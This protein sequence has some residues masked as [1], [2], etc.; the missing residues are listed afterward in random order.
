MNRIIKLFIVSIFLFFTF[1]LT[2]AKSVDAAFSMSIL[3]VDQTSVSTNEQE[4]TVTATISGL[5]NPSFF[6][7]ELQK[8]SGDTYFGYSKNNLGNW[9]KVTSDSDCT[10]YYSVT[11]TN[12][13]S[14]ILGIKIGSDNAPENGT[15]LLKLRRYTSTCG[16][17]SDSD[18]VTIQINLPTPVPSPTPNPTTVSTP[19]PTPIKT[20]APTT[21]KSPTPRP[22]LTIKPTPTPEVLGDSNQEASP[23][24]ELGE[25][26]SPEPSQ[27][28]TGSKKSAIILGAIFTGLGVFAMG[29]AGYAAYAKSKSSDS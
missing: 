17:S 29:I 8:S 20:V 1:F 19:I 18:P 27:V 22:I 14:L 28:K 24:S 23:D 25:T 26:S 9:V 12:I 16:S 21:T 10:N 5:P 11:D 15:Y 13:T 2:F 6:R 4:I 3:S 7:V